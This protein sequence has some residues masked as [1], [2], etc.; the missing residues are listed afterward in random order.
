MAMH[1]IRHR[2]NYKM[3]KE[4]IDAIGTQIKSDKLHRIINTEKLAE[5]VLQFNTDKNLL[6]DK[7][8]FLTFR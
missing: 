1:Y 5:L 7:V 2:Q 4:I 6:R 8:N 3:I